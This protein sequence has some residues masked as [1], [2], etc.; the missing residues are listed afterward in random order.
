MLELIGGVDGRTSLGIGIAISFSYGLPA[1]TVISF[2]Y[3][4]SYLTDSCSPS[5]SNSSQTEFGGG[6]L[7]GD[8]EGEREPIEFIN[9]KVF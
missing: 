7:G 9:N 4:K 3:R 6:E 1:M 8:G 2:L 5:L